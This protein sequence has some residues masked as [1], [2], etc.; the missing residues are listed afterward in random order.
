MA[1]IFFAT[2][3]LKRTL[4][5]SRPYNDKQSLC[6]NRISLCLQSEDP[7]SSSPRRPRHGQEREREREREER[8]KETA[9]NNGAF[10]LAP[11]LLLPSSSEE[12]EEEVG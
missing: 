1:G 12:E 6:I 2:T 11:S 10:L 5:I 9:A 3:Y 7:Q 8:D 4:C